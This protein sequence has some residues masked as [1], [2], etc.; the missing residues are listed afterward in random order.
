M[1]CIFLSV[2]LVML[3]A[4]FVVAA[5]LKQGKSVYDKAC[6]MCHKSGIAGSPKLDDKAAWKDRLAQGDAVLIEHSIKGFRGSKGYMPPK[7]G[8]ASLTDAEVTDAVK[9]MISE[10][11]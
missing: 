11:K 7:G 6:A 8:K 1:R 3:C 5:D 2:L 4:T 9:Y 10:V